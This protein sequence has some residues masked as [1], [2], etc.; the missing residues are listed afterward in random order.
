MNIRFCSITLAGLLCPLASVASERISSFH[1]DITIR[2]DA[3]ITVTETITVIS[4]GEQIRHGIFRDFPTSYTGD[5]GTH[6]NIGFSIQTITRD[7]NPEPY[8]IK[9]HHNG[10]TIIIGDR[11]IILPL[12]MHTYSLT[13][14]TKR[15]LGFFENHDELYW[16]V[17]GS[18]WRFPIDKVTATVTLPQQLDPQKIHVEAYTG[19]QGAKG[20]AYTAQVTP[21]GVAQFT[22]T[23]PLR[24][25]EGLTIVVTWPKGLV[26]PPTAWM[27]FWFFVQD[28]YRILILLLLLI[29]WFF[30]YLALLIKV[31]KTRNFGTII[32]LF[33][34]PTTM[35]AA[36]VY[37]VARGHL[38]AQPT[39]LLSIATV[40]AA[41][42]GFLTISSEPQ[43]LS[44]RYTLIQKKQPES[45][46]SSRTP[47]AITELVLKIFAEKERIELS[48]KEKPVVA[49]AI[50]H[51]TFFV[52]QAYDHCFS[53]H[54]LFLGGISLIALVLS[55]LFFL[56]PWFAGGILPLFLLLFPLIRSYT[57][58]G[59]QLMQEIEGF[60]LF[61]TTTETERLEIIG[62]PP[63][64]TP[65]LYE[66]YLP[67]AMA[68]G[69]EKQWTKQFTPVFAKLQAEG[70]PYTPVWFIGAP[71]TIETMPTFASSLQNSLSSSISSSTT[72]PGSSSGSGGGGSSGGGGGGGGGGGW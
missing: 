27:N 63:T 6:Y 29:L 8:Q 64:R 31:R 17:T 24:V 60:K 49:K 51:L 25:R 22:T 33:T 55:N 21:E 32:P 72:I 52:S 62:T 23:A 13:Y 40:Q 7:A 36:E 70:H 54:Y 58:A 67:Y 35:S 12:G 26:T 18:G 5:W 19:P 44:K 4:R 46:T 69:V 1:S 3:S 20:T 38:L 39:K 50:S 34:P 68:L 30:F 57:P 42:E 71:F 11:D 9:E 41:V 10:V 61:L 2:A 59:R 28:N 14:T 65:E 16:N 45:V 37:Y 53:T 56:T 48:E 15:Q 66:T 47:S 43:F